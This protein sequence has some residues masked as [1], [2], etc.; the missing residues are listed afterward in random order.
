MTLRT[1][2][3]A[4]HFSFISPFPPTMKNPDF[5]PSTDPNGFD[6]EKFHNQLPTEILNFL[7]DK[8]NAN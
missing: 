1:I 7:N 3:N 6:R 5:L 4:G 8:L 2:E